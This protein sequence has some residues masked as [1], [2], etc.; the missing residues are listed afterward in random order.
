MKGF[1]TVL[2]LTSLLFSPDHSLF[3]SYGSFSFTLPLLSIIQNGQVEAK[4]ILQKYFMIFSRG[5]SLHCEP[6]KYLKEVHDLCLSVKK[7]LF[8]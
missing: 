4:G 1:F 7:I 2:C 3:Q 5:K 6:Q 8:N